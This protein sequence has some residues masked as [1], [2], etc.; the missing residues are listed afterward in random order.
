M[1]ILFC[2]IALWA[3]P[4]NAQPL[5]EHSSIRPFLDQQTV[6]VGWLDLE[7][8]NL[9]SLVDFSSEVS[10]P[11]F[12]ADGLAQAKALQ[13]ALVNM[14]AKR[15]YWLADMTAL[16]SNSFQIVVPTENPQSLELLLSSLAHGSKYKF[17]KTDSVVLGGDARG[18]ARLREKNGE[19]AAS[20]L[21]AMQS[22]QGK[23]GLAFATRA[24]ALNSA[25]AVIKEVVRDND[26]QGVAK[27]ADAISQIRWVAVS[28]SLPP[29]EMKLEANTESSDA[30]S[31][32][33]AVLTE[34]FAKAS[35][36]DAML[37]KLQ[38]ENDSVLLKSNSRSE[39]IDILNAVQ[40]L[41]RGQTGA[42][43][44]ALKLVA[45]A[46]HNYASA[47]PHFPPQSLVA[48]DGKRLLSWRVLILPFLEYG[49]L[50][51]KF[52]LDEPWDSPHNLEL[53]KTIPAPYSQTQ[54][55]L[56][57]TSGE[58]LKTRIVAPMTSQTVFGQ[59]GKPIWF[60]AILDG[61]SN[62]IWF[63]E[64]APENAVIWTKP[65]D[66]VVD[67]NDPVGS[68]FGEQAEGV[69]CSLV[70]GVAV[71]LKRSIEP[72]TLNALLTIAGKEVVRIPKD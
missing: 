57:S 1:R 25:V 12:E 37:L 32:L 38:A 43:A 15:V 7:D 27:L 58:P 17:E 11:N 45:L 10:G 13:E 30:A 18:L 29:D 46:I 48:E 54:R 5:A 3:C 70:D 61:T 22:C 66:L 41:G 72:E 44:R 49:E 42:S 64:T 55:D 47:Y 52:R 67:T 34:R 39:S 60:S 62:T 65:E 33:K 51:R 19:P 59:P 20:L 9:Q 40:N 4:L 63:L 8:L 28:G 31:A 21:N 56:K 68:I 53:A 2:L 23:H 35:K 69:Y 36:K 50:Y 6:L 14:G 26:A 16:T 71:Y 24:A